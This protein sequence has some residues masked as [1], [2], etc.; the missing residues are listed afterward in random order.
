MDL[1][2]LRQV[3]VLAET[4][5]FRRAAERL[6]MAQPPLSVSIR[7]LEDELGAQLFDRS[8][9]GVKLTAVGRSVLDHARRALFHAEQFRQ[10][11]A[12]ATGGQV[13]SLRI[14]FVASSTVRLLPKSIAHFRAA[15]PLVELQL[16]E[17]STD[18]IMLAL[19]D[20]R[21]DAAIVRYPTPHQSAVV[22]TLLERNHY[23]AALPRAH[24]MAGRPQLKLIE[25]RDEAFIFP[26][27]E[28]G[29]AAYMSALLA[30]QRAGFMPR[31]VQEAG[32]AQ[33]I[34]ALVESGLGVALVP[35]VWQ[36]LA[37]RAVA[38]RPL[39]GMPQDSIG[40]AFACR[41]DEQD[42]ALIANFRAS[43]LAVAA[44][45]AATTAVKPLLGR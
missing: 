36:D 4:L 1:K 20:G 21:T 5:N 29:S 10:V 31:I 38:F 17:A 19:R 34:I 27:R 11:A 41:R 25:L 16:C 40:L 44:R 12:L 7:R 28:A 13:G 43:V 23:V 22:T 32:H 30:C 14:D 3:L 24:P 6:H 2:Q 8:R 33:S 39:Q 15:F 35:D 42:A 18:A 37:P 9:A 26:S 45:P